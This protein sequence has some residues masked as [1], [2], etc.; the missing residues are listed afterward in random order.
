MHDV[1]V[2]I[3][4]CR[5]ETLKFCGAFRD[6][7]ERYITYTLHAMFTLLRDLPAL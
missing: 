2:F 5:N 7:G 6:E 3:R 1:V 4:R